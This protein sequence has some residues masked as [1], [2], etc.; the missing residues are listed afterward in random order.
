[1]RLSREYSAQRPA[2]QAPNSLGAPYLLTSPRFASEGDKMVKAAKFAAIFGVCGA[3][4]IGSAFAMARPPS[5]EKSCDDLL[6][7]AS[8][9]AALDRR[10]IG[11]DPTALDFRA[12]CA[13]PM[14]PAGEP[15]LPKPVSERLI[16]EAFFWTALNAC[17]GDELSKYIESRARP[18]VH[19]NAG[20]RQRF[21]SA[22]G[23]LRN[24]D[25][26]VTDD[27]EA[28]YQQRL[29]Q[30]G[31]P[32]LLT[33]AQSVDSGC[34][35]SL[36]TV[37]VVGILLAAVEAWKGNKPDKENWG[38][39][40]PDERLKSY[41]HGYTGAWNKIDGAQYKLAQSIKESL[42][43]GFAGDIGTMRKSAAVAGM[44]NFSAL[45]LNWLLA[46]YFNFDRFAGG[47]NPSRYSQQTLDA[48]NELQGS[49]VFANDPPIYADNDKMLTN[50]EKRNVVCWIAR[51]KKGRTSGLIALGN[52]A[53]MYANGYGYP[54]D[55]SK[56]RAIIKDVLETAYRMKSLIDDRVINPDSILAQAIIDYIPE[57]ELTS[58]AVNGSGRGRSRGTDYSSDENYPCPKRFDLP[59][60]ATK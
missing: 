39:Y 24:Y 18:A 32:G 5:A 50:E 31:A 10:A 53:W 7:N 3:A 2:R 25:D 35:M 16:K 26:Y 48:I 19:Y 9:R 44:D 6:A 59:A 13:W 58:T 54:K 45:N 57:W 27:A 55:H 36:G 38:A 15:A 42:L 37:E 4:M 47:S 60:Q 11:G 40:D 17:T 34:A 56:A 43:Q 30:L 22:R 14:T 49:L 1:M 28:L 12:A 46:D 23:F 52:L 8:Q 51:N 20:P 21:A 41:T 29:A 33:L